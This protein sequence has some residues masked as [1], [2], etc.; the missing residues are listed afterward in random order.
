MLKTVRLCRLAAAVVVIAGGAAACHGSS[1]SN[2]ATDQQNPFGI[3]TGTDSSGDAVT[4]IID[5]GY[6]AIFISASKNSAGQLVYTQYT[7]L[8]VP[9]LQYSVN[10]TLH[11][12]P[13]PLQTFADG[14]N[15]GIG[16]L[17]GVVTTNTDL[18]GTFSFTTISNTTSTTVWTLSFD[19]IYTTAGTLSAI[20]GNYAD[21]TLD[22]PSDGATVSI[23]ASGAIT[24]QA[25]ATGCALTG[26][27]SASSE[28]NDIYP[29]TL[30]YASCSGT[31]SV[32]NSIQFT[33]FAVL[34]TAVSPTAV[35][36]AVTGE[37]ATQINY[38]VVMALTAT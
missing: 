36:I 21:A 3:F 38:G 26:T 8:L 34:N 22:D 30:S 32:L 6:S 15:F 35:T 5:T 2:T 24:A 29:V 9:S 14:S 12:Y 1:S 4:A 11:G 25:P 33:G 18:S 7:G 17:G 19:S 20:A 28:S 31:S 37:S 16:T 27:I 10:G 23:T 13:Q